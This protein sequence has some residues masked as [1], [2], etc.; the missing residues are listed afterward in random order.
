MIGKRGFRRDEGFE[1]VV[2]VVRGAAAPFGIGGWRGV[3]R[4]ARGGVRRLLGKHV[5]EAGVERAFDLGTAA[6]V[7]AEPFLLP[8]VRRGVEAVA[9]RG[10]IAGCL[11]GIAAGCVAT[12]GPAVRSFAGAFQ[13]RIALQFVFDE[14][15]EVEVGQ[16]QELDRLHQL[17][18]HHQRLRLAEL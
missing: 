14:G 2:V 6:E 12:L 17:R 7:R 5:V 18:R 8:A 11:A 10:F 16:L 13:Q 3:L 9:G 15:G 4:G 1:I